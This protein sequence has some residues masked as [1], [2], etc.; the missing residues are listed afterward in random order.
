MARFTDFVLAYNWAILLVIIAIGVVGYLQFTSLSEAPDSCALPAGLNCV[1][2]SATP[3]GLTFVVSNSLEQ[4]ATLE[5]IEAGDCI[6]VEEVNL[7]QGEQTIVY[8]ENCSLG[9]SGD[10]LF[11]PMII[12]YVDEESGEEK[13]DT[14]QIMVTID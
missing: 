12:T 8:L 14:G 1:E 9:D 3:T 5:S 6:T 4:D 11:A 13:G 7:K 2:F 10:K